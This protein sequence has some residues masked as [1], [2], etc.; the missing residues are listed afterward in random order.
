LE[1]FIQSDY[2]QTKY[3]SGSFWYSES[4]KKIKG[5]AIVKIIIFV[6]T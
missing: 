1:K 5:L 4:F 6:E 2:F 3:Y